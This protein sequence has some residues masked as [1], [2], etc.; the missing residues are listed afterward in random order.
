[1]KKEAD[2]IREIIETARKIERVQAKKDYLE[3]MTEAN[4][5][6][7]VKAIEIEQEI[8]DKDIEICSLGEKLNAFVWLFE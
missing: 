6:E 3:S 4:D 2:I 8:L 5:I 7:C 1:M